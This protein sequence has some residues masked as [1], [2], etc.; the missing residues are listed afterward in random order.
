M[1]SS[2]HN[3]RSGRS[4]LALRVGT[5]LMAL[6]LV[7]SIVVIVLSA[8]KVSAANSADTDR[9]GAQAVAD[10]FALRMD[11]QGGSSVQTYI[12]N[13][14]SLVTTKERAQMNQPQQ[15]RIMKL[16][17]QQAQRAAKAKVGSNKQPTGPA[18]GTIKM[19]GV[20]DADSDSATVLVAH[21]LTIPGN[22]GE[23]NHARWVVSLRKINGRWLVDNWTAVT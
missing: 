3:A 12:H 16:A 5:G 21:D 11:A 17:Y 23:L 10:Q 6:I 18:K 9:S 15:L 13:I 1:I 7:A 8:R 4:L 19:S 22:P 2:P 14:E 20:T